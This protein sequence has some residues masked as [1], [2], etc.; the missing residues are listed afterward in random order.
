MT[1]ALTSLGYDG[2]EPYAIAEHLAD[3]S[4]CGDESHGVMQILDYA[5][6]VQ[7]DCM[8]FGGEAYFTKPNGRFLTIDGGGGQGI[9]AMQL[10]FV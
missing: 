2:R 3:A 9:P 1:S 10:A 5:R 6:Q 4:L 7:S 8:L